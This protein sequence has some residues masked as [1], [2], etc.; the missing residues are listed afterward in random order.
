MD[1]L[2]KTI[3]KLSEA[4]YQALL[5]EVS[6]KKKN[7]PYLVLETT[8][9]NDVDDSTMMELLQVNPSTY[10]TLKSRLN[11]KIAAILSKKVNNP[12]K[13]LMDEVARVPAN[14]FG[15][16]KEFSI[17]ALKDLE[18]QLIEYDLSSELIV[19]Y[20]T[21]AE[22][23]LFSEE[24]DHY[25]Q[26]YNKN[27]AFSLAI[28]K[29]EQQYHRFIK[30]MGV[31]KLTLDNELLEELKTIMKQMQNICELYD[32]HRLFVYF[33][34]IR[35]YYLCNVAENKEG[36]KSRELEIEKILQEM[37]Q[38]FDKYNLDTTYQ[39]IKS[40]TDFLFFEYYQKTNN[41]IRADF[42][43]DRITPVIA[44]I[45]GRHIM[46]FHVS[47]FLQS[48]ILKYLNDSNADQLSSHNDTLEKHYD[49][50]SQEFY[51]FVTYEKF[52]AISKFYKGDFSGS[53]KIVN[54]LRNSI[55][56]KHYLH[57][58]VDAKLFQ[59]LQYCI[60]G[61]DGLCLQIISS[62]KRQIKAQENEFSS[63]KVFVKLLKA[64]LKPAD[65][66]KKIK[67]INELWAEFQ[68]A[69]NEAKFPVLN[70]L[71]LDEGLIRK[72]TNPIKE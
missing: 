62:L 8:R 23:H 66:R 7:K 18:K 1:T 70:Y 17:R 25:E 47:Q 22:L 3:K 30:T 19:V 26:L 68:D 24:H 46:S 50:D 12:I 29:A 2:N 51:H 41:Q 5:Q 35:I 14:L 31:Y 37:T 64:A 65:Y 27:V 58:D 61:E 67:K 32:S 4:E 42:Y 72:I 52:K 59:S 33:N 28:G 56:L 55:S 54:D 20:K 34:I 69:N 43:L 48:K 11:T 63:V 16:N 38:I 40:L 36:L 44:D 57:A 9:K 10:Y 21:L 53:A 39:N 13:V 71:K 60:M 45:S 6:G 49:V 15:T